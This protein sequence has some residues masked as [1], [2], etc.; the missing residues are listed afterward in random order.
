[1]PM[2]GLGVPNKVI[3]AVNS[4]RY[5]LTE[6]IKLNLARRN[7]QPKYNPLITIYIPTYNRPELLIERGLKSVLNQTYKNFELLVID[8]GSDFGKPWLYVDE[9]VWFHGLR[10]R[11]HLKNKKDDWLLGPTRAANYALSI[12]SGDWIARNDDDDIWTPDHL[13]K[14]L[15]FA[16]QNDYEFV[17]A[18]QEWRW[19]DGRKERKTWQDDMGILAKVGGIQTTLYRSYLKCFKFNKHCWRK[20]HN[21]NN[22]IDLPVRM[23]NAGVRMG[24]LDEVVTIVKPRPN[25]TEIGLKA[26]IEGKKNDNRRTNPQSSGKEL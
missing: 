1:M 22:D 2:W 16:Q 3:S 20:S 21:R 14:L 7:W 4:V 24:F 26:I 18:S 17:S 23:Y 11:K 25:E 15:R 12:A 19:N 6:P 8:D 10:P 13:E 9:R 5:T